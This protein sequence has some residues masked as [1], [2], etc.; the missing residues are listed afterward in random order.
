[1]LTY[2]GITSKAINNV[3]IVTNATEIIPKNLTTV[4]VVI[5]NFALFKPNPHIFN[6]SYFLIAFP[7]AYPDPKDPSKYPNAS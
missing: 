1:M 2:F 7:T 5:V 6:D 4:W 3:R